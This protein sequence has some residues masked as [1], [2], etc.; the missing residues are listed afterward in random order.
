MK[1]GS[2]IRYRAHR[3]GRYRRKFRRFLGGGWPRFAALAAALLLLAGGTWWGVSALGRRGEASAPAAKVT[4]GAAA[5]ATP[6]PSPVAQDIVDLTD[7]AKVLTTTDNSL[8]FPGVSADGVLYAA[9]TGSLDQPVLKTLY[10][11]SFKTDEAEKIAEAKVK[12]GEIYETL[13]NDKWF[14]WVDTNR[15]GSNVIRAMNRES[16]EITDLKTCKNQMPKLRMSGDF[17]IFTEQTGEEEDTLYLVDLVSQENIA[18][19]TFQDATTYAV[20]APSV[21]NNEIVWAGAD[22][23]DES[24]ATSAIYRFRILDPM[25]DDVKPDVIRTGT[26]VH[27]PMT[28]GKVLVWIDANKGPSPNLY[29]SVDGGETKLVE[30]AITSYALTD[31][32]VVYARE[33]TIYLYAWETDTYAQLTP[34]GTRAIQPAASGETVVWYDATDATKPDQLV[35]RRV[36][37]DLLK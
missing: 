5:T 31:D 6:K 8:G 16:K 22:P 23:A 24:G 17:V 10:F 12:N 19:A 21:W 33:G 13:C 37:P 34:A 25:P 28:N 35:Y 20:S 3:S 15:A 32:F 2:S 7:G 4:P 11:H 1:K 27:E 29:I 14:V 26:Y 9:G 18:L 30:S 36:T